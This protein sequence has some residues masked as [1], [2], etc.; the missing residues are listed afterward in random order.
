MPPARGRGAPRDGPRRRKSQPYMLP[1]RPGR[2]RLPHGPWRWL[3]SRPGL[4]AGGYFGSPEMSATGKPA[5]DYSRPKRCTE[6]V[7]S[8]IGPPRGAIRRGFPRKHSGMPV[9]SLLAQSDEGPTEPN[10]GGPRTGCRAM[11]GHYSADL[12]RSTSVGR[13]PAGV[14]LSQ[15]AG[16]AS[17]SL[18]H[19]SAGAPVRASGWVFWWFRRAAPGI[20]RSGG[21]LRP[22]EAGGSAGA[23]RG[24][25]SGGDLERRAPKI[26]APQKSKFIEAP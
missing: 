5:I 9:W 15:G 7:D 18:S 23:P 19:W 20:D 11:L 24:P 22:H 13:A 21:R 2:L 8:A 25:P 6:R 17:G 4:P 10:A 16:C 1:H 26:A 12:R 3:E 14:I